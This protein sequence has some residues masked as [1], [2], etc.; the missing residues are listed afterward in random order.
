MD[1]PDHDSES[2]IGHDLVIEGNINFRGSLLVEGEVT[3]N[4]SGPKLTVGSSG[5]VIGDIVGKDLV[6]EGQ[7][8]GNFEAETISIRAQSVISGVL[9]YGSLDIEHGARFEGEVRKLE[10]KS[11]QI[12][13]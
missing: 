1:K 4:I 3:G 13:S 8:I 10:K 7:L 2:I 6:V 12:S 9:A 5:K 11:K